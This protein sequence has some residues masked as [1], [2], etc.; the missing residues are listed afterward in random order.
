VRHYITDNYLVVHMGW[1]ASDARGPGVGVDASIAVRLLR[2]GLP[3]AIETG[4]IRVA[5]GQEYNVPMSVSTIPNIGPMPTTGIM[6]YAMA[7]TTSFKA[8]DMVWGTWR[9]CD[10]QLLQRKVGRCRSTL[11]NPR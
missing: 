6:W 10:H 7:S 9:M 11:S 3:L 8:Y 5:D 4:V 2:E 1:D